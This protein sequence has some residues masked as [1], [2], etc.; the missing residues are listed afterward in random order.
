MIKQSFHAAQARSVIENR[1]GGT[2]T[3][4]VAQPFAGQW[5]RFPTRLATTSTA[6]IAHY[7]QTGRS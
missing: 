7:R 3:L 4:V 1:V 6:E 5:R 2:E